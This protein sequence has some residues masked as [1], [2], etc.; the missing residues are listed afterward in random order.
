MIKAKRLVCIIKL[1]WRYIADC[2]LCAHRLRRDGCQHAD[3]ARTDDKNFFARLDR[4]ALYTVVADAERFNQGENLGV[5]PL[6]VVQTLNR[7]G[8]VL[9]KRAFALHAHGLVVR[10]GVHKSTCTGITM[11]AVKIRVAGDD[12]A[13]LEAEVVVVDLNDFG[14]KL[15]AGNTG[16]GDIGVAAAVGAKVAAADASVKQPEKRFSG[17]PYRLFHFPHGHLAR[18]INANCFQWNILICDANDK[19]YPILYTSRI[20]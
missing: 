9:G 1:G 15:M 20:Y 19:M 11:S 16:I 10:A 4:C 2:D 13:R 5:E 8:N 14:G 12:H 6:T 17:F 7:H 18:L 3:R